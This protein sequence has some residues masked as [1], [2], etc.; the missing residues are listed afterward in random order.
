METRGEVGGRYVTQLTFY[1][2]LLV[3][4]VLHYLYY[5]A[6]LLLLVYIT[7]TS[8]RVMLLVLHVQAPPAWRRPSRVLAEGAGGA[9]RQESVKAGDGGSGAGSTHNPLPGPGGTSHGNPWALA[10]ASG[11]RAGVPVSWFLFCQRHDTS[12]CPPRLATSEVC[13]LSTIRS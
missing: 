11:H 10:V 5:I 8:L 9:G 13:I 3:S 4:L 6:S 1:I 7:V 12:P 2:T